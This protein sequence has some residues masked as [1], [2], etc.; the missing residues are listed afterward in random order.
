MFLAAW[1]GGS[2]IANALVT[3]VWQQLNRRAIA[4]FERRSISCKRRISAQSET[5][6]ADSSVPFLSF[7]FEQAP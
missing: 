2:S 5:F 6:T 7:V 1:L 3:V 4:A